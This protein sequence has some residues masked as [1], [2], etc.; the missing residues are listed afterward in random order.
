[1]AKQTPYAY[2]RRAT[3]TM[4]EE[5]KVLDTTLANS[6]DTAGIVVP[7]SDAGVGTAYNQRIGQM[8]KIKSVEMRAEFGAAAGDGTNFVQW[9]IIRWDDT[10]TPTAAQLTSD[11]VNS[12][13]SFT[14]INVIDKVKTLA[15]G[16]L[17][18]VETQ[19]SELQA[20]HCYRNINFL[21]A[22]WLAGTNTRDAG[23]L[24]F[25]A[26]SD[27]GAIAHPAVRG[28]VRIRYIG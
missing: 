24:Y 17:A 13:V 27:S 2:R 15:W 16:Q 19:D 28:K 10:G 26:Y 11:A 4:L 9:R 5:V 6:I 23:Q 14:N 3:P 18:M 20:V 21:P 7:I 12:F 8:I 22:K 1:M 25:V